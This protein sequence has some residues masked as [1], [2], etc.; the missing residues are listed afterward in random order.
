M[1]GPRRLLPRAEP[2]SKGS[3]GATTCGRCRQA[4]GRALAYDAARSDRVALFHRQGL[5][6]GRCESLTSLWRLA[7]IVGPVPE[8]T[9][10]RASR[11]ACWRPARPARALR[12]TTKRLTTERAGI[13]SARSP[14]PAALSESRAISRPAPLRAAPTS[15][16]TSCATIAPP[17]RNLQPR[18]AD[19]RLPGY[20]AFL[21]GG[22]DPAVRRPTCET[23]LAQAT[24]IADS[25][26][27]PLF[28]RRSRAWRLLLP[29]LRRASRCSRGADPRTRRARPRAPC[30]ASGSCARQLTGRADL[31]APSARSCGC[32]HEIAPRSRPLRA[33]AC[34]PHCHIF[35]PPPESP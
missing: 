10:R 33:P 3:R 25:M 18:P 20:H 27:A 24:A 13:W 28:V 34:R 35:S 21:L 6:R 17:A 23:L 4:P 12:S 22:A 8:A 7:P 9:P 32:F 30:P 2:D 16:W 31:R 26:I 29:R 15:C 5:R 19:R 11:S 14:T 1:I